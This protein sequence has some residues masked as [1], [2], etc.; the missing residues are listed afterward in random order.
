MLV[1]LYEKKHIIKVMKTYNRCNEKHK[2]LNRKMA[3]V[4]EQKSKGLGNTNDSPTCEKM[5]NLPGN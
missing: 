1:F 4:C 5:L 2:Q 3:T